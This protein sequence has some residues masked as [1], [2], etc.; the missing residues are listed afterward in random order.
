MSR[1]ARRALDPNGENAGQVGTFL[2][3]SAFLAVIFITDEDDC[4]IQPGAVNEF[5]SQPDA[6]IDSALGPFNSYR[7]FEFGV[8]CEPDSP[9]TLGPKA[10]CAPRESSDFAASIPDYIEFFRGLKPNPDD[11]IVAGI[12]GNPAPV[13]V[14]SARN[15]LDLAASCSSASGVA[16]PGVRLDAFF[17]GF[18]GRST[19]QTICEADL[20]GALIQI[21][22]L[23]ALIVG[24]P[25][26]EGN[27]KTDPIECQVS[28]VTDFNTPDAVETPIPRC[29]NET[30]PDQSTVTPC[31]L[32][33]PDEENCSQTATGLTVNVYPLDRVVV[34]NVTTVVRCVAEPLGE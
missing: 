7:C 34:G 3:D 9:R 16:A 27:I 22:E 13:A 15:P 33:E 4:S 5:F 29:D 2:R 17:D 19:V 23:L 8:Q 31:F 11:V 1:S 24:N 20:S 6:D 32:V 21:A 26:L 10:E 30:N 18:P 28:D 14:E 25:C 12:I